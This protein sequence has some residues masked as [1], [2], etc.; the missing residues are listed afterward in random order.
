MIYPE[1]LQKAINF[2]KNL[3]GVGEKTAERYALSLCNLNE[4]IIESFSK[5]II[6]CQKK[7]HPCRKCGLITDQE[8]CSICSDENRKKNIICVLEDSKN[9]FNFEK[10]GNYKGTYHVLNG[11]ISPIDSIG[12]DDINLNSLINKCKSLKDCEL[13]IAL[14][15][16]IEGEAT[17]LFIKKM[18]ENT[19]V[20]ISRLSYGISIGAEIDY[21]DALTLDKA[22]QDRKIIS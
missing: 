4:D 1:T 13:I 5:T 22:L 21:L 17:T 15:S 16:S 12:P 8:I 19:N 10:I 3:P 6:D 2:F 9:V 7:L 11:L 20:K 18:L 14:K